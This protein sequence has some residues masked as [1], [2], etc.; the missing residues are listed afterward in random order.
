VTETDG[1]AEFV[2]DDVARG[3]FAKMDIARILG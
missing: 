2:G 3:A 1:V